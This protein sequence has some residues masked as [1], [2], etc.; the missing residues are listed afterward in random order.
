MKKQFLLFALIVIPLILSFYSG[1]YAENNIRVIIDGKICNMDE[2]FIKDDCVFVSSKKINNVISSE[3]KFPDYV[4]LRQF[5]QENGFYVSWDPKT[6]TANADFQ[7]RWEYDCLLNGRLL[8]S[9]PTNAKKIGIKQTNNPLSSTDYNSGVFL[10]SEKQEVFIYAEELLCYSVGDLTDDVENLGYTPLSDEIAYNNIM[11][12]EV[13]IA[14][15]SEVKDIGW[16]WLVRPGATD[17][18]SL[19]DNMCSFSKYII[20]MNDNSLAEITVISDSSDYSFEHIL[21]TII[22]TDKE[23][24]FVNGYIVSNNFNYA[25]ISYKCEIVPE[26]QLSSEYKFRMKFLYNTISKYGE[27]YIN[28][29]DLTGNWNVNDELNY[30]YKKYDIKDKK[31]A[32][33]CGYYNG[34][35]QLDDFVALADSNF[36]ILFNMLVDSSQWYF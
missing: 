25:Y 14:N 23:L 24:Q 16:Q 17:R 5:A 22:S 1:V 3:N 29:N 19:A 20:R 4:P 10:H 35:E 31:I 15:V 7:G 30:I 8:F 33:A 2:A 11:A 32:L 27:D 28:E 6:R 26:K 36:E 13:E 34:K 12:V 21:S 18:P 9:H